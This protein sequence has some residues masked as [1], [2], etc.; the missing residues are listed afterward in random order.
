[1]TG[2]NLVPKTVLENPPFLL[3]SFTAKH[4]SHQKKIAQNSCWAESDNSSVDLHKS[5]S[6]R[7]TLWAMFL[8]FSVISC[9]AFKWKKQS[10]WIHNVQIR[11][12][13]AVHV[14]LK[15]K[16]LLCCI[17]I[18]SFIHS[19]KYSTNSLSVKGAIYYSTCLVIFIVRR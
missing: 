16:S 15:T 2:I 13:G 17:S 19:M 9:I 12:C 8:S 11:P 7:K 4:I 18:H 5:K 14:V 6:K 10:G 3:T 1:M